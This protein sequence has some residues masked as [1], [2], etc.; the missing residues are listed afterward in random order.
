M[1]KTLAQDLHEHYNTMF[2]KEGII[3]INKIKHVLKETWYIQ[4]IVGSAIWVYV[5]ADNKVIHAICSDAFLAK[6]INRDVL[7]VR[8]DV[9]SK[10]YKTW[11]NKKFNNFEEFKIE[12]EANLRLYHSD[13]L[14]ISTE[15]QKEWDKWVEEL[16]K[17]PKS[18]APKPVAPSTFHREM[19]NVCIKHRNIEKKSDFE[20]Y[21]KFCYGKIPNLIH[22]YH[23]KRMPK[24][25]YKP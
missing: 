23:E 19:D 10:L 1:K 16:T 2:P 14:E 22:F 6:I 7:E 3:V 11:M 20:H 8:D 4:S 5:G 13:A 9:E 25:V 18:L 24:Q 17:K 12:C 21:A 15:Y